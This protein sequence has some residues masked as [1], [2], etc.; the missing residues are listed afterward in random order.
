MQI[1]K[2]KVADLKP[3][4]KNAKKHPKEQIE[5]IK[6]SIRQ[7]G[8]NDPIGI[9]EHNM[10]IEGHGRLLAVKEL[11][12]EEVECICLSHLSDADKKAYILAHNKLTMNTGFDDTILQSEFAFLRESGIDYSATGFS[13]QE[14]TNLFT[15]KKLSV[16]D[17]DF[18]VTEALA[19][20]PVTKRGDI[21]QIG[22]HRLM[23]GDST[24]EPDVH[25]LMNGNKANMVFTDPPWNVDYGSNKTHPSWKNRSILNDKMTTE[26]FNQFLSRSFVAMKSSIVAGAMVYIVMSAQEWGNIM[27]AMSSLGFHWSSTIIWFKDSLV[28]SR[29]DYHTQYEPIYFGCESEYEPV[30]YGWSDDAKRVCPLQD[31]KQSDVWE[32]PRPKRSDEHPTMKPIPLVERAI[33][34]SSYVDNIVLDLFGGSGTTMVACEQTERICYMMELD[35]KYCDV[36]V[37]RMEKLTGIKAVLI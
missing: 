21:W 34:N 27:E 36:I 7:F 35:P 29:K 17:D 19:G 13:M 10:V 5:Q 20:E 12:F 14:I 31:R 9:D 24:L 28:L 3:Y 33:M 18:D 23:C 8:M 2:V 25:T 11:G 32:F 1:I 26:N 15:V 30:W 4:E 6:Q 37:K 16:E 22:N